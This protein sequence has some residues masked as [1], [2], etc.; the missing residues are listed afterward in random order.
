MTNKISFSPA[1]VILIIQ[2]KQIPDTYQEF[3]EQMLFGL[4]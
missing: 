1:V 4:A 3:S 2:R